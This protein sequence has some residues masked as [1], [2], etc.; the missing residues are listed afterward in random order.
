[1]PSLTLTH[2]ARLP[3]LP[4]TTEMPSAAPAVAASMLAKEILFACACTHGRAGRDASW[5]SVR[6]GRAFNN[7]SSMSPAA[8]AAPRAPEGL[9]V[10]DDHG[11]VGIGNARRWPLPR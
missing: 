3:Q 7:L 9:P 2:G 5:D 10:S 6:H 4:L 8:Y 1:M 11:P